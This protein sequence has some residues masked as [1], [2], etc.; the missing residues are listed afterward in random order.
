MFFQETTPDTSGYMIAGYAIAFIVMA[1]YVA[2]LYL[3]ARNLNQDVTMLEEMDKPAPPVQTNPARQ[4]RKSQ[5]KSAG[6]KTAKPVTKKTRKN[7]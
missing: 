6:N 2:S 3:R 1:L 5:T 7:Y 4:A